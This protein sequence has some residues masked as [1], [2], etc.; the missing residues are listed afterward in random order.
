MSKILA[1]FVFLKIK[2]ENIF[3][4]VP[5]T[6]TEYVDKVVK[7]LR[8]D[9]T[10]TKQNQILLSIALKLSQEREK[11]MREIEKEYAVLQENH[12][13]LKSRMSIV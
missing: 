5:E 8:R 2:I 12:N 3:T 4:Y 13:T 1:F 9:F 6:E 7:L 11:D 10:T